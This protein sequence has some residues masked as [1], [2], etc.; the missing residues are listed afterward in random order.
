MHQGTLMITRVLRHHT[1][2]QAS[3]DCGEWASTWGSTAAKTAAMPM[4]AI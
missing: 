3:R 4:P 1:A 2:G